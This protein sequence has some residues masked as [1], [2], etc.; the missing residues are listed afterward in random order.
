MSD[1][2][3]NAYLNLGYFLLEGKVDHGL[4]FCARDLTEA[5]IGKRTFVETRLAA[6]TNIS[7]VTN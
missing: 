7:S 3:I 6:M 5:E 4:G 2:S 1:F